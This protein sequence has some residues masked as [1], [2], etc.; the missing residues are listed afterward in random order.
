MFLRRSSQ[1]PIAHQPQWDRRASHVFAFH[2]ASPAGADALPRVAALATT[3]MP[4]VLR[5]P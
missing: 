2:K 1:P 3:D 5:A 4:L